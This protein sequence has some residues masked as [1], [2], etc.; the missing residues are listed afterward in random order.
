MKVLLTGATGFLGQHVL[1]QLLEQGYE[2]IALGRSQPAEKQPCIWHDV[3]LL[4]SSELEKALRQDRP[5]HLLHLAWYTEHGVYW[6]SSLNLRWVDASLRLLQAFAAQGGHHVLMAGSCAEYD[7]SHGYLREASTPLAPASLYGAAK[8][9]TRRLAQAWCQQAGLSFGWAH[10]FYPFGPGE[11]KERLLPSLI[12]VFLGRVPPFGVNARSYRGLLP[13]HDAGRALV[14]LLT[15]ECQGRFNICSGQPV[16][17]EDVVRCLARLCG[18]DPEPVLRLA[19]ARRG[20]PHLLV[21]D[22]QLLLSTGW[23][24]QYSLEQ[25]LALQLAQAD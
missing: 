1:R 22:N 4:S 21:G 11:G 12:E 8:D 20:D 19:S 24:A 15:Q 18:A 14:H 13:A 10:I 25:G 5:T 7:W 16:A 9:A 23:S 17:I 6:N 3:D 2:V